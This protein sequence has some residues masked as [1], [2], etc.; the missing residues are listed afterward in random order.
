MGII[1]ESILVYP[2]NKV[3]ESVFFSKIMDGSSEITIQIPKTKILLDKHK[4]KCK[5]L[6][7][8]K[9]IQD[10]ESISKDVIKI[11]SEKSK[12]FFGKD[13]DIESC[14]S[15]YRN[16]ISEGNLL[17]CFYSE[18]TYFFDKKT[19]INISDIE[20]EVSGIV[21]LKGDVIVYTKTAFYI[22]WEIQQMKIKKEKE[23]KE[24]DTILTEYSIVDLEID[25]SFLDTDKIANKIRELS[26]F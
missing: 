14:S 18:D 22:R 17:N 9:T 2:P 7:D 16:A 23:L 20:T 15:L 24:R 6:L 5:I 19:Q 3:D 13:L 10:M 1:K 11:T 26:F 25:D 21:L 8:E 4:D 12:E